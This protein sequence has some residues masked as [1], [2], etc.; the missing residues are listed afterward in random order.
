MLPGCGCSGCCCCCGQFNARGVLYY[1]TMCKCAYSDGC[2][3]RMQTQHTDRDGTGAC[4]WD[5]WSR[6]ARLHNKC[7][8][9]PRSSARASEQTNPGAGAPSSDS[10]DNLLHD[11][12]NERSAESSV[13]RSQPPL[14][15]AVRC[16]PN[17]KCAC[18]MDRQTLRAD[19]MRL[20][21]HD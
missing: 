9:A 17:L 13:S 21:P 2:C 5:R 8:C 18:K 10:N 14:H 15:L 19:N 12:R 1:C 16:S 6:R 4:A 3:L 11:E 20:A 7:A